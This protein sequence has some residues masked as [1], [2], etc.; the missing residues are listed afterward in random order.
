MHFSLLTGVAAGLGAIVSASGVLEVDLVFPHNDTY[1]PTEWFP[2]V[3]A[4]QNAE[5]AQ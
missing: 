3:F 1:A 2:I 5:L 4:F